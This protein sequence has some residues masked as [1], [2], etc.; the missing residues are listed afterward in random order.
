MMTTEIHEG[1]E[2]R[3]PLGLASTEGLGL[4]VA[5]HF[6]GSDCNERDELAKAEREIECLR[7][8]LLRE[9]ADHKETLTDVATMV[10]AERERWL[11]ACRAVSLQHALT[12]AEHLRA[13]HFSEAIARL[14]VAVAEWP[15]VRANLE[16]TR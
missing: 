16:P 8:E 6:C 13:A 14:Q 2:P 15:N 1:S 5:C 3:Q 7:A 11:T 12:G 10:A 4:L 9:H